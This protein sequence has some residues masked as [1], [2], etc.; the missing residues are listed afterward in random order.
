VATR[1]PR[2]PVDE[3]L[4]SAVRWAMAISVRAADELGDLSAVQLRALTIL[5]GNARGNLNGLAAAMGVTVS[6]ASRLVDRLVAA[7]LVD[8]RPSPQ[9]RREISLSLTPA[10]R[11]RLQRYDRLRIV[12]ARARLEAVPRDRRD[13]VLAALEQLVGDG[14]GPA[15]SQG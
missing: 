9:T 6:T 3:V 15:P 1:K 5:Q 11:G 12:E 2:D 4:L 13:S 7:G 10:G 8:R 14:A